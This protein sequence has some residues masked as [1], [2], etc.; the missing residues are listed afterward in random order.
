MTTHIETKS[1]A[2][3]D[4]TGGYMQRASISARC[5]HE[6]CSDFIAGCGAI[7]APEW[8][9]TGATCPW[10]PIVTLREFC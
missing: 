4:V 7:D 1:P 2:T 10:G 8:L 9:P 6:G 3:Y 5:H